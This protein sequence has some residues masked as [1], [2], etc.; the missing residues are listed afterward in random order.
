MT[1][2]IRVAILCDFAEER[3]RSMDLVGDMLT[4]SLHRYH[5]SVLRAVKIRPQ[6][7]RRF[8][9]VAVTNKLAW[10]LDRLLN[11]MFDYPRYLHGIINDFDLFHLID[12]SYSHLVQQFPNVL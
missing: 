6:F 12:H 9:R 1:G 7:V 4:E 10:N 3:W 8:S 5:S 2:L 11:R